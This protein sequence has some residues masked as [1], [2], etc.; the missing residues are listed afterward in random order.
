VR[1]FDARTGQQVLD[2]TGLPGPGTPVFSPDGTRIAFWSTG[3]IERGVRLFD[4]RTGRLALVLTAPAALGLPVF[5]PDGAR[6]AVGSPSPLGDGVVRVYDARTGKQVLALT[7][8]VAL[9]AP[10][11]SPDGAR[12]AVAPDAYAGAG[13][14]QPI[15]LYDAQTGQEALTLPVSSLL[16]NLAFSPNGAQLAATGG[17]VGRMWTAPAD[18]AAWQG[19]RREA[20]ADGLPAWHRIRAAESEDTG[21][22]FAAAFHGGRLARAEHAA[23]QDHFH[24]GLAYLFL[25]KA[26]EARKEFELALTLTEDLS[27][28]DQ[29]DAHALLGQGDDAGR[30]FERAVAAPTASAAACTRHAGLRL[31]QGDAEGYRKACATI[32]ERFGK[33]PDAAV[34]NE[35]AWAA[36]LGPEALPDLQPVLARARVAV[37]ASPNDA[38]R[39][40]TLGALLYRAGQYKEAVTD[41]NEAVKQNARGGTWADSLFLAMAHHRLGQTDEARKWLDRAVQVL[42][43]DPPADWGQRIQQ[44]ILRREAEELLTKESGV[45][46]QE[47][48]KKP[49]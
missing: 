49:N 46:T 44:Q 6:V 40:K 45:K 20:V 24:L 16:V 7:G 11:F 18:A 28:L 31:H 47:S 17:G 43:K 33:A 30:L 1:V 5:S 22:W 35:A 37:G 39:R 14:T 3:R 29:A 42:E 12:L 26:A 48:G 15:R 38:N 13:S 32:L 21:R 34:T 2:L 10:V 19:E 23:G 8:S 25:A 27:E 9:G 41:L 4:A 36:A